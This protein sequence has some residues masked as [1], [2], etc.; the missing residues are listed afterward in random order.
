MTH[1]ERIDFC[2]L[3]HL[4]SP[5]AKVVKWLKRNLSEH[6]IKLFLSGDP[7]DFKYP[8]DYIHLHNPGVV[9]SIPL[10][11]YDLWWNGGTLFNYTE[12]SEEDEREIGH[13]V[14]DEDWQSDSNFWSTLSESE[15]NQLNDIQERII[16][17]E[18]ANLVSTFGDWLKNRHGYLDLAISLPFGVEQFIPKYREILIT[19]FEKEYPD[20]I[21]RISFDKG[22]NA[23][24]ESGFKFVY[25]YIIFEIDVEES[26]KRRTLYEELGIKSWSDEVVDETLN[27]FTNPCK[28]VNGHG[29][30]LEQWREF[31]GADED[32]NEYLQTLIQDFAYSPLY[33][34]A[35]TSSDLIEFIEDSTCNVALVTVNAYDPKKALEEAMQNLID[36]HYDMFEGGLDV[37]FII[38]IG[39]NFEDKKSLIMS[40]RDTIWEKLKENFENYIEFKVVVAHNQV[41]I[42]AGELIVCAF[43]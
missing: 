27:I 28:T 19:A 41:L 43:N 26:N 25:T 23:D 15:E 1:Q 21:L 13:L 6:K 4:E 35:Y 14:D 30:I 9:Y 11:E 10:E 37:R 39:P 33:S 16:T 36:E 29:E 20:L 32:T 2:K 12:I 18:M 17:R 42:G 24:F 31:I 8:N 38:Y 40:A 3:R 5:D 34:D 22:W 7:T